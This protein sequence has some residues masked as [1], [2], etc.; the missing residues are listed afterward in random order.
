MIR[1]FTN[2]LSQELIKTTHELLSKK[3]KNINIELLSTENY[4]KIP[5]FKT[6]YIGFFYESPITIY[7]VVICLTSSSFWHKKEKLEEEEAIWDQKA[8]GGIFI[9]QNVEWAHIYTWK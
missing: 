9:T 3:Y 7:D 2:Q 1:N 8:Y 4:W 6:C 5:K